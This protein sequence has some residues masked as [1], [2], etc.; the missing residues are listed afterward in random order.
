MVSDLCSRGIV[1][2]RGNQVFDGSAA[3]AVAHLRSL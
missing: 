2:Q 1:L 3:D